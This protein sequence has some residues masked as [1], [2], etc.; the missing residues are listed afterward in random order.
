MTRADRQTHPL[1]STPNSRFGWVLVVLV[2]LG[3]TSVLSAGA[4][5]LSG[6]P[7]AA[8]TS[9]QAIQYYNRGIELFRAA[10][11]DGQQGEVLQ[12]ARL[13]K[14]ARSS[15]R[16]ALALNPQLVEAYS[17]LGQIELVDKRYKQAIAAFN[18]ALAINPNHLISLNDLA[19]TYGF[20]QQADLA[21]ATYDR[22]LSLAPGE[23]S[24]WY[25][26]GCALQQ[27]NRAT[28]AQ[29]AYSEA[30]RLNPG[31]QQALFNLGTLLENQGNP[32]AAKPYYRRAK[33]ANAGNAIGLEALHRLEWLNQTAAAVFLPS[34]SVQR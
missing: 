11:L 34:P 2:M 18:Q 25:N 3:L 16:Q 27:L 8:A 19:K 12:Q 13:L 29:T 20:N 33:Q 26:K 4:E 10:Q 31:Y 9:V 14:Q 22:L 24:Y 30:I 17:A 6:P 15:L 21:L 32:E 5:T 28:E 23:P 7:V 1:L